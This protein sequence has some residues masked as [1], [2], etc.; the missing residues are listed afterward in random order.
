M[1]TTSTMITSVPLDNG[2]SLRL[3]DMTAP[4]S[5]ERPLKRSRSWTRWLAAASSAM[6]LL[7]LAFHAYVAYLLAYPPVA[8]LSSN[9][10]EALGLDY[11]DVLFPSASGRTTVSGWYIPA[12]GGTS[13]GA[14]QT[15]A[16]GGDALAS[17]RTIVFSHGYGANREESWV[18][19]YKLTGLVH[20]LNYNVLL[21]DYGYAS[22]A[23][24]APAT[25]GAEE[26]EQLLAAVEFAKSR[27][28]EQIV[29]WGFS[30]G[31]GTALQT[32]L[33]TDL[34]DAMILDSLFLASSD[35]L[36]SNISN[37][38]S[39]PRYPTVPLI[40]AMMPIWS[41]TSLGSLP[42]EQVLKTSYDMPIYIIHGT[43]DEKAS[44]RTA[45]WIAEEQLNPLSRSWIVTGGKHELVFRVY[46]DEYMARAAAFLHDVS[47]RQQPVL[48]TVQTGTNPLA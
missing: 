27:G 10:K 17:T 48:Q 44:Y 42:I 39:I 14:L 30:M 32:A 15:A 24:R 7:F 47:E 5:A 13:E 19:M 41:G 31:A 25:G 36:Y 28:A 6:L 3:P 1:N 12:Y 46:P 43:D 38:L 26:S 18:P 20:N 29:V 8:P 16:L 34:I 9:P 40:E 4:A 33:K 22:E 35:T 11:E 2:I 45:E 23:Y 21:F 37:F